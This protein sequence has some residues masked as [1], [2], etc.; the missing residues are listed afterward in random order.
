MQDFER[1]AGRPARPFD[2]ELMLLPV[3][4]EVIRRVFDHRYLVPERVYDGATWPAWLRELVE[5]IG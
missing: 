3:R 4:D 2:V 5:R 1:A